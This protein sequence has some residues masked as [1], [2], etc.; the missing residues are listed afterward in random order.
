MRVLIVLYAL[1]AEKATS[2]FSV[3]FNKIVGVIILSSA[4][5]L[6]YIEK[7]I[8]KDWEFLGYMTTVIL[9]DTIL[10]M[11]YHHKKGSLNSEGFS[12]FY[13]KCLLYA[14]FL[15]LIHNLMSFKVSGKSMTVFSWLDTVAYMSIMVR[16]A[17][18][19]VENIGK[20]KPD[21]LPSWILKKL[22]GFDESGRFSDLND[23]NANG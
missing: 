12:K 5:I 19:I 15:I 22:K 2:I 11:L 6:Y 14:M 16:E 13:I 3:I 9:V 23:T 1:F 21:L 10:A 20:I 18:S 4:T 8:Y 17:I 7:Y